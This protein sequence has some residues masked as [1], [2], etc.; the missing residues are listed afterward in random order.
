VVRSTSNPTIRGG[1]LLKFIRVIPPRDRLIVALDV[2]TAHAAGEIVRELGESVS[3]Y[4]VGLQLFSAEG[5]AIV[6]ELTASGRKVFLDLKLHD[7]PNTVASAVRSVTSL[8]IDLLT[9]HAAG[10]AQMMRAAVEAAASASK[11]PKILAVTVLTSFNEQELA[12]TGMQGGVAEQVSRMA[13]LAVEAG[14][15]GVVSSALELPMLRRLLGEEPIVL[16]PGVRPKGSPAGDQARTAE[17]R[18]AIE[19]GA[20]YL[21]VGRPITTAEYRRAAA[22][23]VQK[24]ISSAMRRATVV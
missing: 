6:S 20:T 16:I 12:S 5:P 15:D 7:I 10:G 3:F 13:A 17:P 24:E 19:A 2:P 4:K 23:A 22:E 1:S 14:C 11:R 8:G 21:V 9:I 18:E